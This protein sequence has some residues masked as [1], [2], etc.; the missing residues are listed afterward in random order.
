MNEY[1]RQYLRTATSSSVNPFSSPGRRWIVT[2][3]TILPPNL[4]NWTSGNWLAPKPKF[5]GCSDPVDSRGEALC[6]ASRSIGKALSTSAG[7]TVGGSRDTR[8]LRSESFTKAHSP[9]LV[10]PIPIQPY[11]AARHFGSNEI[12]AIVSRFRDEM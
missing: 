12:T 1:A 9:L 3:L 5:D 8:T 2:E 10:P 6:E 4:C 11:P 7:C